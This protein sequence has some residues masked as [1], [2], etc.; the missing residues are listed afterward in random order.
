MS[1]RRRPAESDQILGA[2]SALQLGALHTI[3]GHKVWKDFI[4][5]VN[6]IILTDK[7]KIVG[8]VSDVNSSDEAIAKTSKQNFYRGRTSSLVLLHALAIN[9]ERE[10][11]KRGKKK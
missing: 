2:L 5:V 7:E 4:S 6:H 10:I 9:A 8:S 3:K 1:N 11:D